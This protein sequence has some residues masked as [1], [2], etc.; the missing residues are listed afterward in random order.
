MNAWLMTLVGYMLIVSIGTQMLPDQ[1][2]EQY[3]R[4]FAGFLL[5]VIILQPLLKIRGADQFLEDRMM[6]FVRE[7]E[8]AE[9]QIFQERE[10]F[11]ESLEEQDAEKVEVEVIPEVKI[12]IGD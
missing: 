3:L 9:E 7:Q 8:T 2:Y 4:L 6:E 5:L 1:K 12:E 10:V 11:L